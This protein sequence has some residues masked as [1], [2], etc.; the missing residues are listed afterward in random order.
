[1]AELKRT[2]PDGIG[3]LA[4][5]TFSS[6]SY[7]RAVCQLGCQLPTLTAIGVSEASAFAALKP[8]LGVPPSVIGKLGYI[9]LGR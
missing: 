8:A 6:F 7:Y 1:M 5:G 4:N 2:E 9:R 3:R